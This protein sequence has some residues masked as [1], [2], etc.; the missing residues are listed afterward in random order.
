MSYLTYSSVHTFKWF[1]Q[2]FCLIAVKITFL[3]A[4]LC[5]NVPLKLSSLFRHY[6]IFCHRR[7][8]C[9]LDC[10]PPVVPAPEIRFKMQF[11]WI[12]TGL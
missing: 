12:E 11:F 2:C 5:L 4:K 1:K 10:F 3:N 6:T 7:I 8:M 9:F